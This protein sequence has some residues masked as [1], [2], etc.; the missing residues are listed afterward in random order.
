MIWIL[1]VVFLWFVVVVLY[2][3]FSRV[4]GVC[5]S[6][7]F[8][9]PLTVVIKKAAEDTTTCACRHSFPA[10]ILWTK[11]ITHSAC[12]RAGHLIKTFKK[13]RNHLLR[14]IQGFLQETHSYLLTQ[15]PLWSQFGRWRQRLADVG[16]MA[17][18]CSALGAPGARDPPHNGHRITE[19]LNHLGRRRHS[20]PLIPTIT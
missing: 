3:F 14:V 1:W 12:G 6:G 8:L 5:W 10:I 20:R 17:Q 16:R 13:N 18:P 19:T 7:F 9:T 11:A 15:A 2:C 4:L